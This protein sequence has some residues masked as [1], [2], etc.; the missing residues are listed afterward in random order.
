MTPL[1]HEIKVGSILGIR[2][3]ETHEFFYP[4][5]RPGLYS[6]LSALR[7]TKR[8]EPG[9]THEAFPCKSVSH[10]GA[11]PGTQAPCIL[12][13]VPGVRIRC[14]IHA[15]RTV[16]LYERF[17]NIYSAPL[18]VIGIIEMFGRVVECE[19]GWRAEKARVWMLGSHHLMSS[20]L[21]EM[22][23]VPLVRHSALNAIIEEANFQ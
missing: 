11:C 4:P 22:Y 14:G 1:I 18:T 8:W 19:Y 21:A 23:C 6:G 12:W 2:G 13:D 10:C 15:T 3:W 17:N 16:D 20:A 9:Q 5:S 7:G